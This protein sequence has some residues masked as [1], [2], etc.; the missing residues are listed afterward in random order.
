MIDELRAHYARAIGAE[1]ILHEM[2]T[3][4]GKR[5]GVFEWPSGSTRLGV[6]LYA[7]A[8]PG[9]TGRTTTG[10]PWSCSPA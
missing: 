10:T 8:A 4:S 5:M 3:R 1:P 6:H 2:N 7:S 9:T